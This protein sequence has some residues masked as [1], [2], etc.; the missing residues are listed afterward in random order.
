MSE[1]MEQTTGI[2]T[3]EETAAQPTGG[4]DDNGK[5]FTQEEVNTI[6]QERIARERKRTDKILDEEGYNKELIERE[7]NITERELKAEARD[8]FVREKELPIEVLNLIDCS[9]QEAYK[10]SCDKVM[11]LLD[12]IVSNDNENKKVEKRPQ[13]VFKGNARGVSDINDDRIKEAFKP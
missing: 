8:Y 5:T 4:T 2:T 3:A 7:K 10:E 12:K 6:V 1:N 11:L 9:D 13:I